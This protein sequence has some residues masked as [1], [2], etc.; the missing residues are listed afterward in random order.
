MMSYTMACQPEFFSLDAMFDLT[1]ELKLDGIDIVTLYD[2]TAAELRK[3]ADD[4]GIPVVCHTFFSPLDVA[5]AVSDGHAV[6]VAK[7]SIEDAV[8]LGAPTVMI[9]TL[10]N[11]KL[12]R[13]KA[14]TAWIKGLN[15][16][17]PFAKQAD[18]NLTIENFPGENSPFVT[19]ADF[20]TAAAEVDGL[21]LTYDNGNAATGENPAE[22]FTRCFDYIVHAHFKD[23]DI[24]D[25]PANGYSRMLDGRYYQPALVG[26]GNVDQA[27]CLKVMKSSGYSGYINIEY[28]GNKY[29]P[30]EAVRR[31]VD[32]LRKLYIKV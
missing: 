22:S 29:R 16:V 31:A 4:H 12:P 10:N 28:E 17:M 15:K 25:T 6:D 19:S 1:V 21:K 5:A 14:R 23:W 30:D 9:P 32:Y 3:M 7:R 24:I 2:R 8:V 27:G 18:V 13:D 26:E 11:A 20:L